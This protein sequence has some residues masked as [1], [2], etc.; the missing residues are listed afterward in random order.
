MC[1]AR[2]PDACGLRRDARCEPRHDTSQASLLFDGPG[3]RCPVRMTDTT[4]AAHA[5]QHAA[6]A[7]RS[8]S[9]FIS[10]SLHAAD[11]LIVLAKSVCAS[12]PGSTAKRVPCSANR[13]GTSVATR[14]GWSRGS[15]WRGNVSGTY[16]Y[17]AGRA[18]T[19]DLPYRASRQQRVLNE[20][21]RPSAH[22]TRRCGQSSNATCIEETLHKCDL[23][24]DTS[25]ADAQSC[26]TRQG[27]YRCVR[28]HLV[29][30]THGGDTQAD[31]YRPVSSMA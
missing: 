22:A 28:M 20:A 29:R 9:P 10:M 31:A 15:Q 24:S 12:G 7:T 13:S 6:P 16:P 21:G 11:A 19:R 26:V 30:V 27:E 3:T 18:G 25:D 14:H 17:S 2:R 23:A 4:C 5:P 8:D 1:R